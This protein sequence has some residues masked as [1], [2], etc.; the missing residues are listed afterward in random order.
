MALSELGELASMKSIAC[1]LRP[2]KRVHA[3]VNY[4]ATC[5]QRV[6]FEHANALQRT[7]VQAQFIGKSLGVERPAFEIRG[8]VHALEHKVQP[9]VLLAQR[10][11]KVVT[12]H[13]LVEGRALE[14]G[15]AP[16]ALG[17]TR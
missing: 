11:L 12:R 1:C 14:L 10:K 16:I 6:V 15:A 3:R 8:D 4:Q 17:W 5:S 13:S 7:R 2:A 9:L